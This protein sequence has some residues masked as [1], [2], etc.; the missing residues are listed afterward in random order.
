MEVGEETATTEHSSMRRD[1]TVRVR[2]RSWDSVM[3][4]P[5]FR[6]EMYSEM[7]FVDMVFVVAFVYLCVPYYLMGLICAL[8]P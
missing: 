3:Q 7:S 2:C 4:S 1:F 5:R 8:E 6:I